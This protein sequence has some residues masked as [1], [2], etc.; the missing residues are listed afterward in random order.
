MSFFE[1]LRSAPSHIIDGEPVA[2]GGATFMSSINPYSGETLWS[3]CAATAADTDRAVQ[4]A[5]QAFPNWRSTPY[6][7][8]KAVPAQIH[9]AGA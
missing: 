5:R 7:A 9:R 4:T 8:R 3:G 2:G 6:E 1:D